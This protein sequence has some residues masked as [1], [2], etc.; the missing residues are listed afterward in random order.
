LISDLLQNCFL[1]GCGSGNTKC[2]TKVYL[3]WV[4]NDRRNRVF[5]SDN[6]GLFNF[7]DYSLNTLLSSAYD[8]GESV[9]NKVFAS[10]NTTK[11]L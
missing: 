4:G 11:S 1:L 9:Y 5:T 2:D 7:M 8:I 6:Y 3:T 10:S